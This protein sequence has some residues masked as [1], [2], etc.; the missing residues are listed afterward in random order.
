MEKFTVR[1]FRAPKSNHEIVNYHHLDH[2]RALLCI[3]TRS[4]S[5]NRSNQPILCIISHWSDWLCYGSAASR[6]NQ[7]KPG[8]RGGV[9]TGAALESS[10]REAAWATTIADW[11]GRAGE[12]LSRACVTSH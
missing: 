9:S 4:E 2:E 1:P 3:H 8:V 6:C 5:G 11:T 7:K 12:C 10:G